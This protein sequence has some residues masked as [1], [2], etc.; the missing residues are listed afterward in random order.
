MILETVCWFAARRSGAGF[1]CRIFPI[2]PCLRRHSPGDLVSGSDIIASGE[3][4]YEHK[5]FQTCQAGEVVVEVPA[6]TRPVHVRLEAILTEKG[7]TIKNSWDLWIFPKDT[8]LP[9]N[10][11]RYGAP[12]DTWL[13]TW[14]MIPEIT[15]EAL[16]RPG[17]YTVLSERL[18]DSILEFVRSGGRVILVATEGLVRP[19]HQLFGYVKYFFTPPAN[20]SPYEDGQNG[21]VIRNHAMLGG[22]PHEGFAD[23]QFFRLIDE[24]PPLDLEPLGPGS[25]GTRGT[26]HP[27][28]PGKR[29]PR[30]YRREIFW[31]RVC[32][33]LCV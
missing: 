28:V 17:A 9:S 25:R 12:F 18:D 3:I 22:F 14:D 15:A 21:T 1:S 13:K 6:M 2:R 5:P 26:R 30:I 31:Q 27:Q 32:D 7:R 19:H 23:F 24:A 8:A 33:Y 29:S 11:V 10:V 4:A 16:D 20:Y